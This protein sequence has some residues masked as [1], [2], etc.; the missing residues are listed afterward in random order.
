MGVKGAVGALAAPPPLHSGSRKLK[1][2]APA[3]KAEQE[4]YD[5]PSPASVCSV[6]FHRDHGATVRRSQVESPTAAHVENEYSQP[7]RNSHLSA[8]P[9][10]TA[11]ALR[12]R[13]PSGGHVTAREQ[14]ALGRRV[15]CGWRRSLRAWKAHPAGGKALGRH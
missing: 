3:G 9:G 2:W 12:A 15:N 6:S 7:P 14:G 13:P 11:G 8:Y 10:N 4:K 1:F 5:D